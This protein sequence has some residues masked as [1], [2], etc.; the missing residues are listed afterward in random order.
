MCPSD[1]SEPLSKHSRWAERL[2]QAAAQIESEPENPSPGP[3]GLSEA[4]TA[5]LQV[6]LTSRERK[7]VQ[8]CWTLSVAYTGLAP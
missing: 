7:A 5:G 1:C 6:T 2:G 3:G 8:G 4:A